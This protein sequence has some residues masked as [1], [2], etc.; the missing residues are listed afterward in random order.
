MKATKVNNCCIPVT[1]VKK[2][3]DWYVTHLGCQ[4]EGHQSEV[5]AFLRL[6]SGPDLDLVRVDNCVQNYQDGKKIPILTLECEGFHELYEHLKEE[7]ILV[8]DVINHGWVG[9]CF[10]FYDLDDNKITIWEVNC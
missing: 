5:H 7:G 10:D 3:A 9:K 1:D 6:T 2:S 4:N 8:E